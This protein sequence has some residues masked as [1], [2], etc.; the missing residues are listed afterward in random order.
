MPKYKVEFS[1]KVNSLPEHE[2]DFPNVG[3]AS[4]GAREIARKLRADGMFMSGSN[5][6]DW[7]M[8]I[9]SEDG[10]TVAEFPLEEHEDI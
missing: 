7:R 1:D 2:L 3:A 9:M 6:S 4:K 8:T 5:F 10:K